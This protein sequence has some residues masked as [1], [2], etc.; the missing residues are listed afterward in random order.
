MTTEI[1]KSFRTAKDDERTKSAAA[2][3]AKMQAAVD[4]AQSA[5]T[6]AEAACA[7]DPSERNLSKVRDARRALDDATRD[8]ELADAHASKVASDVRAAEF[9]AIKKAIATRESALTVVADDDA[10][11]LAV[12]LAVRSVELR[13]RTEARAMQRRAELEEIKVLRE[14]VG[15]ESEELLS[16]DALV[17]DAVVRMTEVGLSAQAQLG[18]RSGYGG[19]YGVYRFFPLWREGR[20]ERGEMIEY[21]TGVERFGT[22]GATGDGTPITYGNDRRPLVAEAKKLIERVKERR[23]SLETSPVSNALKAAAVVGLGVLAALT[24]A[25]G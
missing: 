2:F 23:V 18:S 8:R 16:V 21:L 10:I 19:P 17:H 5:V 12:E 3:V 24:V 4:A 1:K 6:A 11:E 25:G 22:S 13:L 9:D 20:T 15:A 14:R 7:D